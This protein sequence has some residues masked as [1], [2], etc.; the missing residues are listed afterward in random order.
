MN[1]FVTYLCQTLILS[2]YIFVA[3][4]INE[5]ARASTFSFTM[6]K[7]LKQTSMGKRGNIFLVQ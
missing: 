3:H 5:M 1:T 6:I 7:L 4:Y 2:L